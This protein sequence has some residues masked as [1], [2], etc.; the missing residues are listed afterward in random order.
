MLRMTW[1]IAGSQWPYPRAQASFSIA[2]IYV[3]IYPVCTL[4]AGSQSLVF[5]RHKR[6]RY[7]KP[8][9]A[10]INRCLLSLG[11]FPPRFDGCLHCGK[12]PCLLH[13]S[14]QTSYPRCLWVCS[15]L[16]TFCFLWY[17]SHSTP[18]G[19]WQDQRNN[20]P[21][22]LEEYSNEGADGLG[23]WWLYRVWIQSH[24]KHQQGVREPYS[25]CCPSSTN[26]TSRHVLYS[27]L[28]FWILG[29]YLSV[30]CPNEAILP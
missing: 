14:S 20:R 13:S 9:D 21:S 25:C 15:T 2:L 22:S 12:C 30:I 7:V 11:L 28:Y 27:F 29:C 1:F 5:D 19:Q 17:C 8:S 16:G 23:W 3:C 4:V 26:L 24:C 6:N 18:L 10:W